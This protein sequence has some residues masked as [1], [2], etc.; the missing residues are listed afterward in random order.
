MSMHTIKTLTAALLFSSTTLA[1]HAQSVKTQINFAQT[2]AG[3]AANSATNNIYVA[4]P[5]YGGANDE[6]TVINGATDTISDNITVPR[7]AQLPVVDL[8]R[9]RIFVVGCD[10]YAP[11]FVCRVTVINGKTNK[12]IK[13][14]TLFTTP[15]DGILGAAFDPICDKLYISNG[16]SFRIDVVDGSSLEVVGDISTGGQEPFGISFNPINHRLYVPYYTNEVQIFDTHTT[17][18]LDTAITGSQDIATAVNLVTGNVFVA[19][20][21]F[22]PSTTAVLDK[23][24]AILAEVTVAD[25]P[26]SLDVDPITN[27]AFV[28]STGIPA[29]NIIDG[30]T[31]TVSA[32]LEG[33][34]A[35]YTS[36]NFASSKVYLSGNN[37]VIVVTEQ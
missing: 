28:V 36:V 20:N 25:T 8:L 35:N 23:N 21:V 9:N 11:S 24:G 13:T 31:N 4:A 7:G 32:T 6:V 3:I 37:G 19:D 29:L 15:G 12:V 33:V 22:G 1:L 5:S 16:S 10:N 18:L 14:A 34:T 2:P 27:K 17:A 26:S 30:K